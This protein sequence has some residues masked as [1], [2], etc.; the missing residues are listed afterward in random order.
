MKLFVTQMARW[1]NYDVLLIILFL[2]KMIAIILYYVKYPRSICLIKNVQN[3]GIKLETVC[4]A[5][6]IKHYVL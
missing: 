4:F 5:E 1:R 3:L 6:F 2:K